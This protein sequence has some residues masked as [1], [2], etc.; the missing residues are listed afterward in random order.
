MLM[1]AGPRGRVLLS[2]LVVL[3]IIVSTNL[4]AVAQ[5][6]QSATMAMSWLF[7][8]TAVGFLAAENG[9][10][11]AEHVNVN[12]SR[13]FGA[14]DTIRRVTAGKLDFGVVDATLL[15]KARSEDPKNQMVMIA[16]VYQKSPYSV[17]YVKGRR[18]KSIDDLATATFGNTGGSAGTLY[19][20]FVKFALKG[21]NIPIADLKI[22]QLQPASRVPALLRGDAD[23]VGSV[24]FE[25][26]EVEPVAKRTG[27]E[28]GSFTYA[29]YGFNPY[30]Y[31]IVANRGYLAQHPDIA[32]AV[33]RASLRGW[34]WACQNPEMAG[35]LLAQKEPDL[36]R[37]EVVQEAKIA[38]DAVVTPTTVK[39]G[40]GSMSPQRWQETLNEA[41]LGYGIKQPVP[42]E[43]VYDMH[44]LPT[45]PLYGRCH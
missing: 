33:V 36:P 37:D 12:L 31:G 5:G 44:F 6:I 1:K 3:A 17:I 19:P 40:I 41:V 25:W 26:P 20:T 16:T 43:K 22:I 10:Y 8:G 34:Q 32:K 14:D 39:N 15:I 23:L 42:I 9:Y 18:V 11:T 29:D 7:D 30:T 2:V 13:G 21:K 35:D 28:L 24:I 27:L 45:P 38:I 4:S